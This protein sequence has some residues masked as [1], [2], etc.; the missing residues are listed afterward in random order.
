V[1]RATS[2]SLRLGVV[3]GECD[4]NNVMV[5]NIAAGLWASQALMGVVKT[6][7]RMIPG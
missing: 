6:K 7:R 3:K 4:D 5:P 1:G 2:K